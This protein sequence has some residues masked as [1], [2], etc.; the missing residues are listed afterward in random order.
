M[1][2]EIT[3]LTHRPSRLLLVRELI[4]LKESG[5]AYGYYDYGWIWWGQMT[6]N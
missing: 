5:I 4:E 2:A 3:V 6:V 1:W